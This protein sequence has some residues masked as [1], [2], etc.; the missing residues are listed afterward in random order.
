[1]PV[2]GDQQRGDAA[3]AG[4]IASASARVSGAQVDDAAGAR[5]APRSRRACGLVLVARG[6]DQ[7]AAA[8]VLDAVRFA[9]RVEAAA[10]PRTQSR[11]FRL[12]GG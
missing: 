9:V 1:M 2:E 7:L 11:A 4:S 3:S 8:A 6:D 12:P 5:P 10:R